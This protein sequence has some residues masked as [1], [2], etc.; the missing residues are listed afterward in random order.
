MKLGRVFK[1]A[2]AIT[3]VC[4][5]LVVANT[6]TASADINNSP[7]ADGYIY[8]YGTISLTQNNHDLK[9]CDTKADGVGVYVEYYESNGVYATLSDSNGSASPCGE[10]YSGYAVTVFRGHSRD[11]KSTAPWIYA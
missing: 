4:G 7:I 5:G 10:I 3:V 11:G 1:S 8:I 6:A 9:V 2:A